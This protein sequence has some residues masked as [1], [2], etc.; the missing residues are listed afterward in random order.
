MS[1][2]VPARLEGQASE[3]RRP[4][5]SQGRERLAGPRGGCRYC[6]SV[7][8]RRAVEMPGEAASGLPETQPVVRFNKGG[9]CGGVVRWFI[10]YLILIASTAVAWG[11]LHTRPLVA[12]CVAIWDTCPTTVAAKSPRG[13]PAKKM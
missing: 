1:S 2:C 13:H 9:E 6:F 5:A 11:R 8:A 4:I 10:S 7:R 3:A 12:M